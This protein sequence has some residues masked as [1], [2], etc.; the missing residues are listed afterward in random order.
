MKYFLLTFV[1]L[2]FV[3]SLYAQ[4]DSVKVRKIKRVISADIGGTL[5]WENTYENYSRQGLGSSLEL[6]YKV[7]GYKQNRNVYVGIPV[8]YNYFTSSDT[9]LYRVR[10]LNFG[11]TLRHDL[12]LNKKNIPFIAYHV[13]LNNIS[14]EGQTYFNAG[15]QGKIEIGYNFATSEGGLIFAKIFSAYTFFSKPDIES[16]DYIQDFGLKIGIRF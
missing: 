6:A 9:S 14:R 1:S 11:L 16:P 8:S 3:I 13:L 7:S 4:D 5:L 12:F 15:L 2:F 10:N